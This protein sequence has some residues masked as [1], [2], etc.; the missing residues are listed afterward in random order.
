MP[1][2]PN[3]EPNAHFM[4]EITEDQILSASKFLAFSAAPRCMR[5]CG[6]TEGGRESC[7]EEAGQMEGIYQNPWISL[8]RRKGRVDGGEAG[9]GEEG[10]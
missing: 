7:A 10:P 3:Q 1:S 8:L 2:R 5:I 9:L 6:Y 4:N